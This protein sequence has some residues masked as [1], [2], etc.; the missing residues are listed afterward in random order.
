MLRENQNNKKSMCVNYTTLRQ[1]LSDRLQRHQPLGIDQEVQTLRRCAI[2]IRYKYIAYLVH[3]CFT[4][5][6]W[7]QRNFPACLVCM[8]LRHNER[9]CVQLEEFIIH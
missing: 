7:A 5:K 3:N 2:I 4:D 9:V 8:Y 1:R 6:R